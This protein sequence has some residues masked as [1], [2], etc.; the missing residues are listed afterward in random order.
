VARRSVSPF[1]APAG[2]RGSKP[3]S[4]WRAGIIGSVTSNLLGSARLLRSGIL[5][6]GRRWSARILKPPEQ[7]VAGGRPRKLRLKEGQGGGGDGRE[8]C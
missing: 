6:C 2:L 5:G 4:T 1:G 8:G 3:K 7:R